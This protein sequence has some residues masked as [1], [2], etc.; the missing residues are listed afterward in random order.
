[1]R[2]QQQLLMKLKKQR[3][4]L[5]DLISRIGESH[6]LH[7]VSQAYDSTTKQIEKNLQ[8]LRRF[9]ITTK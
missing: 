2:R 9:L 5:N 4:L 7:G 6:E 1:M 8:D 3:D